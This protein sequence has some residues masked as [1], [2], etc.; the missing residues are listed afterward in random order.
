[1]GG[2]CAWGMAVRGLGWRQGG[3]SGAVPAR[4]E[5]SRGSRV[6]REEGVQSQAGPAVARL[7][8]G[9]WRRGGACFWPQETAHVRA[10]T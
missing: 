2:G 1:M 8:T 6:G 7:L 9:S 5:G 10:V 3:R 4:A